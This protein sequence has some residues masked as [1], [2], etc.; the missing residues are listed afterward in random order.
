MR[1]PVSDLVDMQIS[2]GNNHLFEEVLCFI[3]VQSIY[4]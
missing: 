3:L 4:A 1:V 2:N